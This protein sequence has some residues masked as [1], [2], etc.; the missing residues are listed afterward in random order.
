MLDHP[1]IKLLLHTSFD[2]VMEIQQGRPHFLGQ[3]FEGKLVYTGMLDELFGFRFGELPYRSLR[4]RFETLEMESYQSAPVVNYPN[5][6]DF[7]RITE[8]K[9]IHPASSKHTVILKE[10]PEAYERG[11]NIP[12][13]PIFTEENQ[14]MY[15][16]YREEAEKVPNLILLGRLAEYRYYDMDDIVKRAL[17]ICGTLS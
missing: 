6:Y 15:R 3:P 7:T 12:Y 1:N 17:D 4:M 16:R 13:Y 9:K 2:E 5:N 14:A 11:K 10:Y 8:F